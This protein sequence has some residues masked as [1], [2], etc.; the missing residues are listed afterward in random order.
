MK[1]VCFAEKNNTFKIKGCIWHSSRCEQLDAQGQKWQSRGLGENRNRL[2]FLLRLQ[3][4]PNS[5]FIHAMVLEMAAKSVVL[6]NLNK[7]IVFYT[8]FL[9]GGAL[10]V[11]EWDNLTSLPSQTFVCTSVGTGRGFSAGYHIMWRHAVACISHLFTCSMSCIGDYIL[12]CIGHW[13]TTNYPHFDWFCVNWFPSLFH[14]S[15]T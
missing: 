2:L 15:I 3:I 13:T 9:F 8:L 6:K 5:V 10:W 12:R 1:A 14:V 7:M 4:V 11:H